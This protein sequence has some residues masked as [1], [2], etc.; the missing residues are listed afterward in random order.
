MSKR[1]QSDDLIQALLDV[2]NENDSIRATARKYGIPYSTLVD[3]LRE[4]TPV[5]ARKGPNTTLTKNVSSYVVVP[6]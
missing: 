2:R 6:F 3:K 4:K 5:D 1:Y